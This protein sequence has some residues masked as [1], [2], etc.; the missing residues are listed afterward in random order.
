M[1]QE[2]I[3]GT[4]TVVFTKLQQEHEN[5]NKND[6]KR[7][8]NTKHMSEKDRRRALDRENLV[9]RQS[10]VKPPDTPSGSQLLTSC[11]CTQRHT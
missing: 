7:N 11:V 5:K 4:S 2:K 8:N 9:Y 1:L 3:R 10:R 6:N